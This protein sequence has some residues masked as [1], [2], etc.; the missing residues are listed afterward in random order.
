M[1]ELSSTDQRNLTVLAIIVIGVIDIL[2]PAFCLLTAAR[3]P[4]ILLLH[5]PVLL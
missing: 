1:H 4:P 5:P 3:H 2:L